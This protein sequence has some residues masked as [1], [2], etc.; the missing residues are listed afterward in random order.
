M[1]LLRA[2]VLLTI[3]A[4]MPVLAQQ[5][6]AAP[7]AV[8]RSYSGA[9]DRDVHASVGLSGTGSGSG[10]KKATSASSFGATAA[11]QNAAWGAARNGSST[12]RIFPGVSPSRTQNESQE[13][14][15][16]GEANRSGAATQNGEKK[17]QHGPGKN[18][19]GA[20]GFGL[21]ST[22][23]Q[24]KFAFS[25]KASAPS[26]RQLEAAA[27]A[28]RQFANAIQPHAGGGFT[29]RKRH[30]KGALQKMVEE[31]KGEQGCDQ[32]SKLSL[33]TWL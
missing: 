19:A 32:A 18:K 29:K 20:S 15:V 3:I 28:K 12:A 24:G 16:F 23:E 7:G 11:N 2:T 5:Q 31:P 30:D 26:S 14:A 13:G 8:E 10:G 1:Q 27:K 21:T 9:V 25:G 4:A 33:C 22:G 6:G 17:S